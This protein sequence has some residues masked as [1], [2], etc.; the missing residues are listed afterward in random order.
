MELGKK[1]KEVIKS[2]PDPGRG[3]KENAVCRGDPTLGSEW[4]KHILGTPALMSDTEKPP[5]LVRGLYEA[6]A[7]VVRHMHIAYLLKQGREGR[8][9]TAQVAAWFPT[10]IPAHTPT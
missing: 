2:E 10:T 6:W 4:F 1:E 8:L 7:P 3:L 5:W 9:K